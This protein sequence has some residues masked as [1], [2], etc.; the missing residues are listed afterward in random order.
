MPGCRVDADDGI[1][2]GFSVQSDLPALYALRA[3]SCIGLR[4][5]PD[6]HK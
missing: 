3:R 1:D 6:Q 4:D 5:V 2:T